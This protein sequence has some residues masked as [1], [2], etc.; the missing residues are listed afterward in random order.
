MGRFF[1]L[2]LVLVFG[3]TGC[4]EEEKTSAVKLQASEV[5]SDDSGGQDLGVITVDTDII[6][7][8]DTSDAEVAM[9]ETAAV[10]TETEGS[11]TADVATADEVSGSTDTSDTD[12]AAEEVADTD[13]SDAAADAEDV[14]IAIDATEIQDSQDDLEISDEADAASEIAED[15]SETLDTDVVVDT[16]IGSDT[17][18][19][20]D[21]EQ[22]VSETVADDV[23]VDVVQDIQPD[24]PPDIAF[25]DVEVDVPPDV[26]PPDPCL[27]L[28]CDDKNPCT[29]DSCDK[30]VGC[31]NAPTT[32]TCEDGD[33]CTV[34]DAC[35][36][37]SCKAGTTKKCNDGNLCTI[38]SCDAKLGCV[39]ANNALPCEDG[40]IC[41]VGEKCGNGACVA[42]QVKNCSD[43]NVC[44]SDACDQVKGCVN[45]PMTGSCDDG[46]ACTDNEKCSDGVCLSGTAKICDD[47][48]VCTSN[49]CDAANGCKYAQNW[50]VYGYK[51]AT[52]TTEWSLTGDMEVTCANAYTSG[53]F[54]EMCVIL[55]NE[56]AP[57]WGTSTATLNLNKVRALY[58]MGDGDIRVAYKWAR[59]QF[60]NNM[61]TQSSLILGEGDVV[62]TKVD[63]GGNEGTTKIQEFIV[64][65]TAAKLQF[66]LVL[67]SLPLKTGPAV[68]GA[69]QIAPVGCVP[70]K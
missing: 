21:V 40:D 8:A 59:F 13:I 60:A 31:S 53:L 35:A 20:I 28:N 1:V 36:L 39:F 34:G 18:T 56:G 30:V 45:A 17:G 12:S 42:G 66:K 11:D 69:V 68:W 3:L 49:V 47:G 9:E 19:D 26:P 2:G 55:V 10:D 4:M 58:K 48:N 22:D 43:G 6:D 33:A 46:N 70:P 24:A 32:A 51:D 63:I 27:T 25:Q 41:T 7:T 57:A 65:K 23:Q 5:A 50:V 37:G 52:L 15:V 29:L 38:D 62:Q 44:T 61:D 67:D 54:K 14:I 16:D 64:D